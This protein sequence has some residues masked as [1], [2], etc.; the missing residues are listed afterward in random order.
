MRA[1][2]D[3]H[4]TRGEDPERFLFRRVE[5]EVRNR[6]G[7]E[8]AFGRR[9]LPMVSDSHP[10]ADKLSENHSTRHDL[11]VGPEYPHDELQ[12]AIMQLPEPQRRV[13]VLLFFEDLTE[14]LAAQ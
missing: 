8:W 1:L 7:C 6:Q 14:A 2:N 10:G 12:Q 5:S 4:T 13:I 9:S 3:F 11:V